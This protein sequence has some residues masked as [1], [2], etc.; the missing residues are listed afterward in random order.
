M[1]IKYKPGAKVSNMTTPT[2]AG[3]KLTQKWKNPKS[4]TSGDSAF[5]AI[6]VHVLLDG[7]NTKTKKGKVAKNDKSYDRSTTA[8]S[9]SYDF[10]FN[11]ADWYPYKGKPK[12]G[13]ATFK[14]RGRNS[15]GNGPWHTGP[16]LRF[17][18]PKEPT[19]TITVDIDDG[20]VTCKAEAE[21]PGGARER[22]DTRLVVT[23]T[24]NFGTGRK[25]TL[26]D[27][28]GTGT[29]VASTKDVPGSK[30]LTHDQWIKVS[31]EAW[32][33]GLAGDSK[34]VTKSHVFAWPA[35]ASITKVERTAQRNGMVLVSIKT[36]HNADTH[37]VDHV[38][39]QR[40][41]S[42]TA[43]TAAAAAIASGWQDVSGATDDAQCT[44]LTD[45][46]ADAYPTD[47]TRTWYRIKSTH[48][49]YTVYSTA[50]E[51]PVFNPAAEPPHADDKVYLV[52]AT[53]L[54]DGTSL[55]VLMWWAV[56]G[57]ADDGTELSWSQ[58]P[59]AWHSTAGPTTYEF[60][61]EDGAATIGGT[62][63]AHT[64]TVYVNDLE[65]G[66]PVYLRAR[67]YKDGEG[68]R[69]W[70]RYSSKKTG[71]PTSSPGTVT[72]H[73]P[74][75]VARGADLEVSWEHESDRQQAAW[76]VTSDAG[77]VTAEG[78]TEA[79]T[80]PAEKLEGLDEVNVRVAVCTTLGGTWQES[81]Q[82]TV[83][84]ADPPSCELAVPAAVTAQPLQVVV[85]TDA[86]A[87][88]VSVAV[89]SAGISVDLPDG[90]V[91]QAEG[92]VVW[93]SANA[94]TSAWEEADG[95]LTATI[96]LPTSDGAR[97]DLWDGCTYVVGVAVTDAVTG[98]TSA[99]VTAET[100]VAWAHKAG[101]PG[102]TIRV[103]DEAQAAWVEVE[104]PE[105]AA[106]GDV[107][108]LYRMS[109]GVATLIAESLPFGTVVADGLV[110]YA[111][112]WRE[113]E[114]YY[115]VA[116]RTIDG[117]VAWSDVPYELACE[118]AWLTWG[119]GRSLELPYDLVTEDAHAKD[120]EARAHPLDEVP[121]DFGVIAEGYWGPDSRHT[122]SITAD[123]VK[124]QDAERLEALVACANHAGPVFV[125]L[126]N[127]R[128]FEGNA[129][130]SRI[131]ESYAGVAV[132]VSVDV[133]EIALT[134][135]H[136]PSAERGEVSY[137]EW[138]GGA[139]S[140]AWGV[141]YD[142]AG[143][144]LPEWQWIGMAQGLA[145]GYAADPSGVV[146][147]LAGAAK[148]GW[149]WDGTALRDANDAEV[150]LAGEEA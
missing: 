53:P 21:D 58:D 71:L 73:A 37:P 143:Y 115:R 150:A 52:S 39:L 13:G 96:S 140:A 122:A 144:P 33:R 40:L 91:R 149:T 30:V 15:K 84:I 134:D 59:N 77:M 72:L 45:Q 60:E 9:T 44:G 97:P 3:R 136:R 23:Q 66:V 34:H 112:A 25:T 110:P 12:L 69:T 50:A 27:K 135:E 101:E 1:A 129:V 118:S 8:S 43:T 93:S 55:A 56:V 78:T 57:E 62:T 126:P 64:A 146:H 47:G 147:D 83:V 18:A 95:E 128:A 81:S 32:T 75:Y 104:A 107:C 80:I 131:S 88:V 36:N 16:A 123:L 41:Q 82:A 89:S 124:T 68:G 120:F 6:D 145:T 42:S 35:K 10:S 117:D 2:R 87:P 90:I 121:E 86:A 127:G 79:L 51:L 65:E 100:T 111:S 7:V 133:E 49:D 46:L 22:H 76:A 17:S 20:E 54:A 19:A 26:D 29:A 138:G 103:A 4:A 102:A 38:Q 105:D 113:H 61:W 5:G 114:L 67:R 139:I 85:S 108:D 119:S 125:R 109:L 31:M 98:I 116:C 137:P 11:R 28:T 106:L 94:H 70:G 92:D 99:P 63:R 48:D 14:V 132:A 74:A 141:V 24:K 148:T 142:Q 130:P